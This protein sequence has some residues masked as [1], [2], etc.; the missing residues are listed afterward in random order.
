MSGS[1][2]P[3]GH[4]HG[5]GANAGTEAPGFDREVATAVLW[6]SAVALLVVTLVS[7]AAM[8]MMLRLFESQTAR[9]DLPPSPL[10]EANVRDL[11]PEPRLQ[12]TPESELQAFRA[13]QAERLRSYG[14]SDRANGRVHIPIDKAMELLLEDADRLNPAPALSS[15]AAT[16]EDVPR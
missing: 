6:K 15:V 9:L 7:M 2:T 13:Q 3:H 16:S 5:H 8:W 1:P 10:A 14:W 12:V 11:P 4:G